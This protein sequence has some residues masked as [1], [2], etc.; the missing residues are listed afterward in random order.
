[1]PIPVGP[2]RSSRME[3]LPPPRLADTYIPVLERVSATHATATLIYVPKLHTLCYGT[4]RFKW[5]S[6]N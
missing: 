4:P 6:E 3:T 5:H 1:M 2:T